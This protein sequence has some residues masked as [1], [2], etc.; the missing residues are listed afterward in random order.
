[1]SQDGQADGISAEQRIA[2]LFEAAGYE[3]AQVVGVEP[4][5]VDWYATPRAG[6]VRPRT[7]W[8]VWDRAPSDSEAATSGLEQARIARKADR[9]LA[10]LI[11]GKLPE[12]YETDLHGRTS[13]MVTYRR[14]A[15]EISAIADNVRKHVERY[16]RDYGDGYYLPRAART[17]TGAVVDAID[18]IK[19]WAQ[20]DRNS[21]L[22]VTGSAFVGRSTVIERARYEI[23]LQFISDPETIKPISVYIGSEGGREAIQ[24]HFALIVG[25][26]LSVSPKDLG[27]GIYE[28]D[29]DDEKHPSE[30][31]DSIVLLPPSG[32]DVEQWFQRRLEQRTG[33]ERFVAA[34]KIDDFYRL[35]NAPA[36]LEPLASAIDG[37]EP[38]SSSLSVSE[39]IVQLVIRYM[40]AMLSRG[41]KST[42]GS[43][44][45]APAIH[46][47]ALFEDAALEQFALGRT[48]GPG[49]FSRLVQDHPISAALSTWMRVESGETEYGYSGISDIR[50]SN[51]LIWDYFLARRIARAFRE[52]DTRMFARYQFSKE[53][54]LLFLAVLAPEVAAQFTEDRAEKVRAEIEAEVERRLQLTLGHLV[55][56]SVG[57]IRMHLDAIRETI[58]PEDAAK[59][60]YELGRID[61]ELAFQSALA[62][63]TGRWQEVPDD[64]EERVALNEV[65]SSVMAPLAPKHPEVVC[66]VDIDAAIGV[67]A[68]HSILREILHCLIENAFQAVVFTRASEPRVR[69]AARIEGETV[70]VE[71]ID[72]GPGVRAADH[73]RVFEPYFTTKKGGD[74]PLGTGMGL[75]IARRYAERIGAVVGLDP[76]RRPTCFFVRL[77]AWRDTR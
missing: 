66:S 7:Y 69:V 5:T 55:K 64:P 74:Q 27:R 61:E 45:R 50:F 72:T 9:A 35:S 21:D 58:A 22:L 73:E 28:A 25:S 49:W 57:A 4:G 39:W 59:L 26:S 19:E 75:S 40:D 23:G 32:S 41:S 37:L 46:D 30:D 54:V 17:R 14:L 47:V 8:L 68:R 42:R 52:G 12:G 62:E 6:F 65:V 18:Y 63:R 2:R 1:M 20:G 70:L 10:I 36:N 11:S 29:S 3:V 31:S 60:R 53:Y 48:S 43:G 24:A 51:Q 77:V 38:T 16:E 15:L 34:R 13:N 33:Y 44:Q 71:V 76:E 67:R 56:R